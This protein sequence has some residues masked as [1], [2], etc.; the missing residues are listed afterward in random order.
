[1]HASIEQLLELRDEAAGA[2]RQLRSHVDGCPRCAAELARLGELRDELQALA[3]VAPP[4]DAWE[5]IVQRATSKSHTQR[6]HAPRW[7]L[8]LAASVVLALLVVW[9]FPASRQEMPVSVASGVTTPAVSATAELVAESQRLERLLHQFDYEPRVVNAGM[10]DTIVALEDQIAWVDYGLTAGREAG[11]SEREARA[12]W[13]QR[14]ELMNSLV[15]VRYAQA[16][17]ID[18]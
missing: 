11:L 15:H 17:R 18:F 9:L 13:Q 12:L 6:R 5:K 16:Q 3:P 7:P 10:A 1:M 4:G 8:A 14:V 2:S